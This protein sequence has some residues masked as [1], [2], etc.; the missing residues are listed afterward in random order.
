MA[1]T[2]T[3]KSI[4][5]IETPVLSEDA[6]GNSTTV[7]VKDLNFFVQ[8]WMISLTRTY[9]FLRLGLKLHYQP[10]NHIKQ[11]MWL[12]IL[13]LADGVPMQFELTAEQL[14]YRK[15][16][17]CAAFSARNVQDGD[18]YRFYAVLTAEK[19]LNSFFWK[20][21]LKDLD[22]VPPRQDMTSKPNS[23]V[24][25]DV[26]GLHVKDNMRT[27]LG[28]IY[29]VDTR[30]T[31]TQDKSYIGIGLWA[32]RA[33]LSKY[34]ILEYLIKQAKKNQATSTE[35]GPLTISIDDASL[36]SFCT[37]LMFIYTREIMRNVDPNQFAISKPHTSLVTHDT[38]GRLKDIFRWHPLDLDSPWNLKEVTW[39]E[40]HD[41]AITYRIDDLRE[42]CEAALKTSAK[43]D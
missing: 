21:K 35:V 40:L 34:P 13:P 33:I 3:V 8:H 27:I 9:E 23:T 5:R 24:S 17:S 41:A 42:L 11:S 19:E 36:V 7:P 28:D 31:F 32:H 30:I 6:P 1:V 25:K 38:T 10:F 14:Q 18:K 22:P 43:E 12:H 39:E 15:F 29:S 37:V 2:N 26:A 4:L 20:P 16:D